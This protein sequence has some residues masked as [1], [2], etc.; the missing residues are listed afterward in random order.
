MRSVTLV[1]QNFTSTPVQNVHT[2]STAMGLVGYM[3]FNDHIATA[4]GQLKDAITT[5]KAAGIQDLVLDIRYNGGGYLDI[6]S[7][8]AYMIAGPTP[9]A[10]QT[11]ELQQFNSKNPTTNPVTGQR[12]APTD[13]HTTTVGIQPGLAAGQAL[14]HLDLNRVFVLT[15]GTTCSASEA[16]INGLRGVNVQVIQIG[17]VTCGKPY[18]FYDQDNCGTTYFSIQFRGVNAKNFGDY[19]D[20]FFPA[21]STTTGGADATLPGCSVADDFSHTLGDTN[22][23]RLAAALNY[24]MTSA[25]LTGPTGVVKP[26]AAEVNAAQDVIVPKTPWLE[27]RI[28]RQN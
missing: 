25:C 13:F 16:V 21:N 19:T 8:L 20:G 10:G 15:G 14:P 6:A 28:L 4:E 7:E 2:I 17:S 24:R 11:F 18:G 23:G 1:S 9:T 27:N 3:Q 5:L 12:I 22:E 26:F